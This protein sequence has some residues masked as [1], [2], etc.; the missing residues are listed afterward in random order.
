MDY[1]FV[2]VLGCREEGKASD[3]LRIMRAAKKRNRLGAGLT[4]RIKKAI[5]G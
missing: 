4:E 2:L 3:A 1:N 5:Q